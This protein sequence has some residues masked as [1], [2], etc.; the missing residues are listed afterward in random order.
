ME[1]T[2][3]VTKAIS[4]MMALSMKNRPMNDRHISIRAVPSMTASTR[5][6]TCPSSPV[7][8]TPTTNFFCS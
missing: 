3:L 2:E 1:V 5:P 6:S 8:G 4:R 7:M